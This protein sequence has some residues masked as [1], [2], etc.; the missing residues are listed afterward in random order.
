MRAAMRWKP[1]GWSLGLLL[2]LLLG[3]C[4]QQTYEQRLLESQKYFAYVL[5]LDGNLAPAWRMLPVEELRVPLQFREIKAPPPVKNEEGKLVEPEID[6]RQPDYVS[7][8]FPGLLGS[9]EAPFTVVVDGQPQNVK[10]HL[11]CVSNTSMLLLPDEASRA[12]DFTRDLLVLIAEKLM[13]PQLDFS[14]AADR[15]THPRTPSYSP[16]NNFDVYTFEGDNLRIDG[17]PYTFEVFAHYQASIQVALVLV[18]P[19]GIDSSAK[20]N[21]RVP[22]ML[23]RLRVSSKVPMGAAP[24]RGG[25]TPTGPPTP[26]AF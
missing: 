4:G 13:L 16:P 26:A 15:Q 20:L 12:A 6:P 11:Y 9:W 2:L 7:L 3:G 22:L 1:V 23:E 8:K 5:K 17:V 21:E 24:V 10:G 14:T 19:V 18:T 25:S